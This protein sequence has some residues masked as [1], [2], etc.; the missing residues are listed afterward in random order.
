MD[1]EM[2]FHLEMEVE[3]NLRRGMPLRQARKEALLSF[4]GV[5][6]FKEQARDERGGRVLDDLSQDLRFT[7]RKLRRS[8][9]FTVVVVLTLALGVGAN[10]AIFTLVDSILLR[11]L[12]FPSPDR[13]VRVY[14][15][16]P[17]RGAFRG[18]L[19]LP[20]GRDLG[21]RSRMVSALGMYSTLPSG[22][23]FT[24]GNQARELATA[25]V[26]GGFFPALAVSALY[27]RTLLPE[28]EEGDNLVVVLSHAFWLQE[29]GGDPS[30]VGTTLDM[31]G[32]GFRVVGIMPPDFAF[33]DPDV[34]IWT[35]LTVI[36]PTSIPLQLRSVRILNA[37]A[38][39][40]P[41]V[42][43]EEAQ[44]ELSANAQRIQEE[45]AEGRPPE[46]VGAS[47]VP[48]QE[49]MVGDARLALV[50]LLGAVGLILLIACANVA[51]L[52][53]ARGI[54]RG[55]EMALRAALGA[56]RSRLARQL[57]TESV[58]L[59][60]VGGG[61]G[62]VLAF[63]GVE[64]FVGRS[65]EFLPRTW[66][67][68]IR[69]EVLLFTLGISLLTGLVFGLL[70][71]LTGARTSP[72]QGLREGPNRGSTGGGERRVRQ[73]LV[74]AQVAIAIVLLVGAGL[75]ARSLA[76]LQN[77]DPGFRSQGLLGVTL[78]LSD[79][80]F[81]EE[82]EYMGAYR[83][84]LE[85]YR[86]LPGVEGAASIRYLPMRGSGEQ[87]DYTVV[88]QP[89]P[90]QG[91]EPSAWLLQVSQDLFQ[92]MGIPLLAGRTFS[93]DDRA[94]PP[95]VVVVNET[96]ARGAFGGE[97]PVG[98]RLALWGLEAEVVGVV[99]DVHQEGLREPP[100]PTA[101]V[102][103]EQIPRSAMT[104][105]L[106]TAGN[107]L[108]LAGAAR[109]VVTELDPGQA[110]SAIESVEEV[111]EGSTAR[112]RFVTILLGSFAL[113]AFVL[114]ALGIYGVVAYLVARQQHE[115]GIRLALGARPHAALGLIFRRG[116]TPVFLGLGMGVLLAVPLTRILGGLLFQVGTGDPASYLT[117]ATLLLVAALVATL[118]PA[119][120]AL[121]WN[122][123]SLLRRE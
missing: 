50:V 78:S 123:G 39:L 59:G 62:L 85:R 83:T 104:F 86:E 82:E 29:T 42:G 44:A 91:Q 77:V 64:A 71:A 28:E 18:T 105:V 65:L 107:P 52:L 40:A 110:I 4:G 7:L 81:R 122:P 31:E 9:G 61:A 21:E 93:A 34:E 109:Q 99:G 79:I 114:A 35:F 12:P 117:G 66:E 89:P 90:P 30:V 72:A 119:R 88:G 26:S 67:V 5:E 2:R 101:Y 51:N 97:D 19:S 111:V 37:L 84:L 55:Q 70:P 1:Q 68:E 57:L 24:G 96:L 43:L 112:T 15:T 103:Q 14:Q 16:A 48:L 47:L 95:L 56:G 41:G 38:R 25:Y 27:G 80:L 69:W 113:L 75:M 11:P 120:R 118:V 100:V 32:I 63:L 49:A 10:T 46:V 6:R 3:A 60:L 36:D 17:E 23:I 20:D 53:L 74:A 87:A 45:F 98:Q 102:H 94:E 8:P 22:L 54:G 115:I 121:R 76:S 108:Q 116:L 13:L 92:V 33:P 58:L 73:V 106:R